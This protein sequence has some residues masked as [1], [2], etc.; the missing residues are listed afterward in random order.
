MSDEPQISDSE[1][2][3]VLTASDGDESPNQVEKVA[4][5]KR[6]KAWLS[7]TEFESETSEYQKHVN[8]HVQGTG[9]WVLETDQFKRW[10]RTGEIGD[11]WIRGIPGSGKSV[12]AA[13]LIKHLKSSSDAPVLFFFFRQII[14]SNRT[15]Q[16]LIR[17]FL[18]Q[19]L[20]YSAPLYSGLMKVMKAH[21]SIDEV[22][23]D[24]LWKQFSTALEGM[25]K[26][27]CVVDALDEMDAGH[28]E[29]VSS[30]LNLGRRNP[31][32]IKLALT[33]RQLPH[34]EVHL[35]G[36]CLVDLRLDRKNVDRDISIYIS[37]RLQNCQV[38]LNSDEVQIVKDAICERGK[39]LF[40]YARMMM[41][42][43]LRDPK[44][45]LFHLDDLP[46]GLGNMYSNIL[47]DYASRFDITQTF[48]K[49]VLEWVTQS[50]RP[51]RLIELAA[52][53]NSLPD[54]GGLQNDQDAKLAI[55]NSC[56]PLL[57]ICEDEVVQIIHH[58][59]T[60]F[61]LDLNV[62][63]VQVPL[64]RKRQFPVIEPVVAHESLARTCIQYLTSGC[65]KDV[66]VRN[67]MDITYW[68]HL[69]STWKAI[70]D[71]EQ[72]ALAMRFN[73]LPYSAK[74]W[75]LHASKAMVSAP[76]LFDELDRFLQLGSK[77]FESAKVFWQGTKTSIP[78]RFTPL[79]IAAHCG[80]T[81]YVAHLIALGT[82]PNLTDQA[83]RM[84]LT[85]AAIEGHHEV[86]SVLLENGSLKNNP[87]FMGLTPLHHA[88]KMNHSAVAKVLLKLGADP[89]IGKSKENPGFTPNY[90]SATT[91]G[92]TPLFYCCQ[93]GHIEVL[94]E[95]MNY[96]E[97]SVLGCGLH[98]A[99]EMG[100]SGILATILRNEQVKQ[101]I[102]HKD[103]NGNTALYLA[104]C[105]RHAESVKILL[106]HGADIHKRS[107]DLSVRRHLPKNRMK[108]RRIQKTALGFSPI[109]GWART[110]S[111][112]QNTASDVAFSGQAEVKE[113]LELFLD[114]GADIDAQDER[115]RTALFVE[116]R[117]TVDQQAVF[118][119]MLLRHG[120]NAQIVDFDG[121]N[122]LHHLASRGG[123]YKERIQTPAFQLLLNAGLD[124]NSVRKSDGYTPLIVAAENQLMDPTD[125]K[126]FGAD[127]DIQ[128]L[129][130]NTAFH[131][132]CSSWRMEERHAKTW[133][134]FSNPAI[135]N[136]V[137]RLALNNFRWGNGA[138]GRLKSIALMIE[139]GLFLE[140]RDYLG[141][142]PLLAFLSDDNCK[143]CE[144]FVEELLRLGANAKARD[145]H[146]KTVS[147]LS[148]Q[149]AD[150]GDVEMKVTLTKT[151][152][153]AG[154][155]IN[156]L[157]H[158][159]NTVFHDAISWGIGWN[160]GQSSAYAVAK[161]GNTLTATNFEGRTALHL[162][163]AIE[164]PSE[165]TAS[166]NK[167]TSCLE[168]LLQPKHE[169]DINAPDNH[170]ITPMHLAAV[171]SEINVWKLVRA[172]SRIDA[173]T[174]H[175][176]TPLH[177]A[178]QASLSNAVGLL[179]ELYKAQSLPFDSQDSKGRTP[180]HYAARS[181]QP[182]SVKMLIDTGASPNIRDKL[183]RTALHAAAEFENSPVTRTIQRDYD[184]EDIFVSEAQKYP[185]FS[186][187]KDISSLRTSPIISSE[188][189]AK[190]IRQIVKYLLAA[191]TDAG[192][193]D[194]NDQT[195]S[196]VALML[197]SAEV[198]NELALSMANL[199][200]D[201]S[202]QLRSQDP[203][204]ESS[205]SFIQQQLKT[206]VSTTELDLN[207][208]QLLER[209]ISTCDDDLVEEMIRVK[210]PQLV[211]A[212]GT[213]PLHIAARWGLCS[214]M[215]RIIP[216]VEDIN[217]FSPPLLYT[218]IQRT[219]SNIEMV[220]LLVKSGIDLNATYR[221]P[222]RD[223]F[224]HPSQEVYE[225]ATIHV[226]AT[227]KHWWY[228]TALEELL[229]AGGE[230]EV[231]NESGETAL[232]ISLDDKH[233]QSPYYCGFWCDFQT[234]ILL[235]HGVNVNA[236]AQKSRLTPLNTALQSKKGAK[237]IQRL[238]DSGA[239][240]GEG[241]KP[242]IASAIDSLDYGMV[243][244]LLNAGAD[245]N[246]IYTASEKKR[247]ADQPGI[248][249]CLLNAACPTSSS[250][251]VKRWEENAKAEEIMDLL[252]KSGAD[253]YQPLKDETSTSFHEIAAI[254]GL[255]KP[256]CNGSIN[257]EIK[258]SEGRTP[259]HRACN[260]PEWL[261][262]AAK[263][264]HSSLVLIANGANVHAVDDTGSTPLHYALETQ[265]E[266]TA[267]ALLKHGASANA[268]NNLGLTPLH[269]AFN[270]REGVYG[271]Y[272][273]R[274]AIEALLEAGA[275]PLE[276]G[277][278][279]KTALHYLAPKLMEMSSI[280][281][282]DHTHGFYGKPEDSPDESE[283]FSK[284][285]TRF[286]KAGCDREAQDAKG[287][288]PLF[289]YVAAVKTYSEVEP[290]HP[291]DPKE[292]RKMF[293]EHDIFAINDAGENLL[294][295]AATHESQM[296]SP[297]DG[298][299]VFKLLVE[300]GLD[301]RQENYSQMTPLDVAAA[302][303]NENILALFA[304]EE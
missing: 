183:G 282:R 34:L 240:S 131:H 229:K 60:E 116:N 10:I 9:Q 298:L 272:T 81:T 27:Y 89:L 141:R 87:D 271:H 47:A 254:N 154:V 157:D 257:L 103:V 30:L 237:I 20:D 218:A 18:F 231:R 43:M 196:D 49:L 173:R 91:I 273:P 58:S 19:L 2:Y 300:L 225:S 216:Y 217:A 55:R 153:D 7:P 46:D 246:I 24:E 95:L 179:T 243:N 244:V 252:L 126:E 39:G 132:A 44:D 102:N 215:E 149:D 209:I 287:N 80:L 155:D 105:R 181:G 152:V 114:A 162:A 198:V 214:L 35:K 251:S 160:F 301:P 286:I 185:R 156:A 269:Y 63:H 174:V 226:L 249:T 148:Y 227:G 186:K 101:Y 71:P 207:D 99:A 297:N 122:P 68:W 222:K 100:R 5:I 21:P 147:H 123:M 32:S 276:V 137:G 92:Q 213:S 83:E 120:A 197:R 274:W 134:S 129:D 230:T 176:L 29:F 184:D 127:F 22:P 59:F 150:S 170:G 178:A 275:D 171:T 220:K 51:L 36:S 232:H 73:F 189:G 93:N 172:G 203:F 76:T 57:E 53:I 96:L 199:Y 288:T 296:E 211:K 191:G 54:R 278:E 201:E 265:L 233:P 142:T 111:K 78:A 45:F 40:L 72:K 210:R 299:E 109:H 165:F 281:H 65:F 236:I 4:V 48:Q 158:S 38:D 161:L 138:E 117:L 50:I 3:V 74:Y 163:A 124:I 175:G 106:E 33:G 294:H 234:H 291:P 289:Y 200:Q 62:S 26:V 292:M 169:F 279:G 228:Q 188:D 164:E 15:P 84:P 187:P 159:G 115:G 166:T 266:L 143:G 145:Y 42:Q 90:V 23:F 267:E 85:Y 239:G 235:K 253:P 290:V 52:I 17:D 270:G 144:H 224:D 28:D 1:D 108:Q 242:A 125:F 77:D 303:G 195:A 112:Y 75:P 302:H 262:R 16:S 69:C 223:P 193:L 277:H 140:S 119:S 208:S 61:L 167:I 204:G 280:D 241:G 121:G 88:A 14:L 293:A 260:L 128:D 245:P 206:W 256:F 180:L 261:Y 146:G 136:K 268:K 12:V 118:I 94:L 202:P 168:F 56:G 25:P 113:V 247:Y 104:A 255:V 151:L 248:E 13:N 238:L 107:E 82:D 304:R 190:S 11:L 97:P 8:A 177:Y 64:E 70:D 98:W 31:K 6:I 139:K 258:D 192:Q 135:Q 285:Y 212:D 41:E 284:L 264:E 182:E 283:E 263:K 194:E 79:H 205:L 67:S 110:N 86:A 295:S 221:A 133:L 37:H 66:E 219:S 259:L 130:G 250:Y